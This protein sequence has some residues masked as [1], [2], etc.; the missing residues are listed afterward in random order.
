MSFTAEVKQEV[1]LH[2]LEKEE[3]RAE[4]S[5]L[6]KMLSSLSISSG[7]GMTLLIR[8]ENA[9]VS[10]AAVRLLRELYQVEI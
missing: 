2:R 7:R 5:A 3:S 4:L 10:R 8:T 6:V 1:S 9:P